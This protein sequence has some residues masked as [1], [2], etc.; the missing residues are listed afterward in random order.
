MTGEET[1]LY[2][3]GN[4][5]VRQPVI[6]VSGF[7]KD[8]GH[9]FYCTNMERQARRWALTKRPRHVVSVYRHTRDE[10]LK[11]LTFIRSYQL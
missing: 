10:S 6:R 1:Y 5:A 4:V 8:F 2:H 7:Y 3:G 11:T 9:G